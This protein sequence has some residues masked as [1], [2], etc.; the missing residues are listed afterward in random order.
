[1]WVLM[2]GLISMPDVHPYAGNTSE[3]EE[4]EFSEFADLGYPQKYRLKS[5]DEQVNI[6]KQFFP[7]AKSYCHSASNLA[8]PDEAEGYFAILKWDSISS[9]PNGA[10]RRS[11]DAIGKQRKKFRNRRSS[12]DSRLYGRQE[13]TRNSLD[14]IAARQQTD[15]LIIPAQFGLRHHGR[16]VRRVR[17]MLLPGEFGLD[18]F[19]VSCMVLTHPE[20][21]ECCE[22]AADCAGDDFSRRASD[23]AL[24]LCVHQFSTSLENRLELL[25]GDRLDYEPCDW[26]GSVTGFMT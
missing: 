5:I 17:E 22:L 4:L 6:L 10:I 24:S 7:E 8:K 12:W 14:L 19:T 1:M 11:L 26:S 13:L 20:R 9:S 16:S 18:V 25:C 23:F 15:I 3:E 21:F 2:K